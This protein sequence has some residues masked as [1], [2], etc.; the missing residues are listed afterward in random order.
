MAL[1]E[2]EIGKFSAQKAKWMHQIPK[3]G[4][5]ANIIYGPTMTHVK[6]RAMLRDEMAIQGM[7]PEDDIGSRQLMRMRYGD[8]TD[9]E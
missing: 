8:D 9:E 3:S 7:R 4:A 2:T 5:Q 1:K 6:L